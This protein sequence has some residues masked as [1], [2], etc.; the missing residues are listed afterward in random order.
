[1][2]KCT[3]CERT[4]DDTIRFC[5]NC[6]MKLQTAAKKF[7]CMFGRI[8][9]SFHKGIEEQVYVLLRSVFCR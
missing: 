4:Y 9:Q 3:R 6:G 5:T 1:M 7:A 8:C 2:K